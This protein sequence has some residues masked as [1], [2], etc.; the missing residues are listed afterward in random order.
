[1]KICAVGGKCGPEECPILGADEQCEHVIDVERRARGRWI[2][3][4]REV[5]M[6]TNCAGYGDTMHDGGQYRFCPWCGARMDGEQE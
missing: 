2:P 5:I 3:I 4:N 1:M 6:C